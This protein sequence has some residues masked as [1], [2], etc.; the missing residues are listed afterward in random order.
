MSGRVYPAGP[1][2]LTGS[3]AF[4]RPLF[5]YD[6]RLLNVTHAKK[7][8][9]HLHLNLQ[10]NHLGPIHPFFTRARCPTHAHPGTLQQEPSD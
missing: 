8:R 9:I 5:L 6:L 2:G 1:S 10:I 4:V 7:L 3:A